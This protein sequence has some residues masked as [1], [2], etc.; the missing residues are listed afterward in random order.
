MG[1]LA[2]TAW[3]FGSST[4]TISGPIDLIWPAG[5]KIRPRSDSTT[6]LAVSNAAG[7]NFVTFDST[8][9]RVGIGTTT[10]ATRLHVV[11]DIRPDGRVAVMQGVD[12]GSSRG[13]WLWDL[14]D[15]RWG[16]YIAQSGAGRSLA[17]GTAVA[18]VGFANRAI[19]LRIDSSI[20]F[21]FIFENHLEQL[22]FSVRAVDGLAYFR[23]SLML[24]TTQDHGFKLIVRRETPGVVFAVR[25]MDDTANVLTVTEVGAMVCSDGTNNFFN[26]YTSA[27][28]DNETA[29]A[30]RYKPGTG[31]TKIE[32]VSVG[33]VDSGGTGFRV[34]RVPN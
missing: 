19:R 4:Q 1:W 33:A 10:P 24:G 31:A 15:S 12:G 34:L 22:L 29:I 26:V 16:I 8:N 17:D 21:G 20:N 11:G 2:K 9:Q 32:R 7:T 18:G 23:G 13:I 28:A 5:T 30:V 27:L 25:N 3:T 14:T 6:A